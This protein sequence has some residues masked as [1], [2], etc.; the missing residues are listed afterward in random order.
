MAFLKKFLRVIANFHQSEEKWELSGPSDILVDPVSATFGSTD[1]HPFDRNHSELVKFTHPYDELYTRVQV[2]ISQLISVACH[3]ISKPASGT[4]DETLSIA[5]GA[6]E[7]VSLGLTA[8]KSIISFYGIHKDR[9]EET[10]GLVRNS[11]ELRVVLEATERHIPQLQHTH[12]KLAES[13]AASFIGELVKSLNSLSPTVANS[14]S[15]A[16]GSEDFKKRLR[17]LFSR[18]ADPLSRETILNLNRRVDDCRDSLSVAITAI[19]L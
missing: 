5:S 3:A 18:A 11:E 12:Q 15:K 9:D 10:R 16:K 8:C 2:K 6:I 19:E 7:L 13:V 1:Q 14:M 4:L 17:T